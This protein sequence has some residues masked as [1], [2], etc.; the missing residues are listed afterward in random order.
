MKA[1][2]NSITKLLT[3]C[4]GLFGSFLAL[5]LL[6]GLLNGFKPATSGGEEPTV[7]VWALRK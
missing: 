6:E 1:L 5:A 3:V 7:V 4:P 2:A